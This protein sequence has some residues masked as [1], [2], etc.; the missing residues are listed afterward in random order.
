MTN[1]TFIAAKVSGLAQSGSAFAWGAKGRRFKSCYPDQ[2]EKA[3]PSGWPFLLFKFC[4]K[5][6]AFN[7]YFAGLIF[8]ETH[9][10]NSISVTE[11]D[12]PL[13]APSTVLKTTRYFDGSSWGLASITWRTDHPRPGLPLV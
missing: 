2:Y 9:C 10:E 12:W 5:G 4:A 1:M 13:F 7:N 11:S 8:S 3:G 6:H